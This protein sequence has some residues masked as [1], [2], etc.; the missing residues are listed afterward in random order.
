VAC[1][2]LTQVVVG[3]EK[4]KGEIIKNNLKIGLAIAP[5][6]VMR[7]AVA[8]STS[9]NSTSGQALNMTA[10]QVPFNLS[11][12]DYYGANAVAVTR[13]LPTTMRAH[14]RFPAA[15]FT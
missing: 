2:Q 9:N 4:L 13:Q 11:V 8:G 5:V 3:F 6:L 7:L 12:T 10:T 1:L 14:S 15:I